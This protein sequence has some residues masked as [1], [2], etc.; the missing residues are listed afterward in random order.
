MANKRGMERLQ[1]AKA[2]HNNEYY[3]RLGV[4]EWTLGFYKDFFH[5]TVYCPCDDYRRSNFVVYF[6][7]HFREFGLKKLIATNLDIGDGAFLYEYD[8]NEET[9]T[10]LS[11]DGNCLSPLRDPLY[12]QC[13]IIATNPPFTLRE[14]N[15]IFEKLIHL[16]IDH[17]KDFILYG[18]STS[19]YKLPFRY[20]VN[21]D[22]WVSV[23]KTQTK[24]L[25]D[26][27]DG[28][29]IRIGIFL[30]QTFERP[31]P[32]LIPSKPYVEGE[33]ETFDNY[34][35][36]NVNNFFDIPCDYDGW[37]GVPT[38]TIGHM[39]ANGYEIWNTVSDA[40][41][42][43]KPVFERLLTRKRQSGSDKCDATPLK[44]HILLYN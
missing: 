43:G 42:H 7:E 1:R 14:F 11:D 18:S 10:E 3:T 5:G 15:P 28:E 19:P 2:N 36:I 17:G 44:N 33:Y 12:E 30:Y 6:K 16:H 38:T 39:I 32:R 8:G 31:A 27:I 23:E 34:N 29:V 13:D 26:T 35:A 9:V 21:E 4:V 37:M 22:C 40:T 24:R 41:I 20:L 25:Y